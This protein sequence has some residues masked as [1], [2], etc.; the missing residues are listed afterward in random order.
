MV[1]S[2]GDRVGVGGWGGR[3]EEKLETSR[4]RVQA[5]AGKEN[6]MW[7]CRGDSWE[8]AGVNTYM[9]ENVESQS[10]EV[11]TSTGLK[12]VQWAVGLALKR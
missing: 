2:Q 11:E 5:E 8:A 12:P 7:V 10:T 9:K 3:G 4:G 6:R 1:L